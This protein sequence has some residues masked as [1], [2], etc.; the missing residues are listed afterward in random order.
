VT[1]APVSAPASVTSNQLIA[2]KAAIALFRRRLSAMARERIGRAGDRRRQ[3]NAPGYRA[4]M[5]PLAKLAIGLLLAAVDFRVS[6]LDVILDPAGSLLV[7]SGLGDLALRPAQLVA[8]L[9]AVLSLADVSWPTETVT[10]S[11]DSWTTPDGTTHSTFTATTGIG[12]P[13]GPQLTLIALYGLAVVA[14]MWFALVGI[15]ERAR[16]DGDILSAG[17]LRVLRLVQVVTAGATFVITC[18]V[19]AS[20]DHDPAGGLIVTGPLRVLVLLSLLAHLVTIAALYRRAGRP[21]AQ[22][23]YRP[24]ATA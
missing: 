4:A 15:E 13:S 2:S 12:T 8:L 19:L 6:G 24:P 5:R 17:R 21:W 23:R 3:E 14:T 22:R 10:T 18:A 16:A 7:A 20:G 11:Y 9:A 1:S